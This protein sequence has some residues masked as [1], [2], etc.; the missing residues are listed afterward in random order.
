VTQPAPKRLTGAQLLA[1]CLPAAPLMALTLPTYVFLP[2][3]FAEHVGIPVGIVGLMFMAA[4]IFDIVVDPMIGSIQDR[5]LPVR[6]LG[7]RKGWLV[8]STPFLCALVWF[9]F[10]AP[11][12]MSHWIAAPMIMAMFAVYASCMIA[13]LGWAAEI[14]P[15]YTARARN[16]GL[17]Q[18]ASLVGQVG[19]LMLPAIIERAGGTRADGVH[20]M[21][22]FVI[23]ALPATALLA[24]WLVPEPDAPPE[25]HATLAQTIATVSTSRPLQIS[26]LID[27]LSGIGPGVTGALFLWFFSI[28]LEFETSSTLL[29]LVYFVAGVAG[30]PI[31]I[32][33]ATRLGKNR[34]LAGAC[35]YAATTQGLILLFPPA[36]MPVALVG[37]AVAGL[38]YGASVF[39]TRAM[40]ADV[41][42]HDEVETGARRPGMFFGL[43]LT[44]SKIAPALAVGVTYAVLELAGFD[45]KLG[46]DNTDAAKRTLAGL[47]VFAPIAA[48]LLMAVAALNFPIDAKESARLRAIIAGRKEAAEL[49]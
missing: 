42:D 15:D 28:N 40:M 27:F 29:L 47:F 21:A 5:T 13:H 48:N 10:H 46:V 9:V 19:V 24:M 44:T 18:I 23:T 16:M 38:G 49:G 25:S 39:L 32:W 1:F 45:A 35:L 8:A 17:L 34:T 41:V 30:T 7:R 20:A 36:N 11:P 4:R 12:G 22:L 6:T 37:M 14:E 33:L 26:L 3:F 2:P 43:L 31:W